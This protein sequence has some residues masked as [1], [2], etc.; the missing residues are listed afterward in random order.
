MQCCFMQA[1]STAVP[2]LPRASDT[3]LSL[4]LKSPD[5]ALLDRQFRLL[6]EDMVAPLRQELSQLGITKAT[7]AAASSSSAPATSAPK[8]KQ[9]QQISLSSSRNVFQNLDIMGVIDKPRPC[10]MV[11]LTLPAGHRAN[12]CKNKKEREE[13]WSQSGHSTLPSDALVC[14]V[15]PGQ[16]LVFATVARRDAKELAGVA[17]MV[18]LAFEPG[19]G[20]DQVLQYMGKGPL[21][22]TVLVQVGGGFLPAR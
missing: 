21:K 18:G 7:K 1:L 13:F 6:R 19:R 10:V 8:N 16:P 22:D 9:H 4:A 12:R 5:A 11:A 3:H 15:S 20:L 14:V 2:F 17:P